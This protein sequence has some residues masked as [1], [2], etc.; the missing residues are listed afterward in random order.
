MFLCAY[1][2]PR[3][4]RRR[5]RD[6]LRAAAVSGEHMITWIEISQRTSQSDNDRAPSEVA[7]GC[8]AAERRCIISVYE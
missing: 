2:I 7:L 3:W 1:A 8:Q 4:P 6:C 5:E